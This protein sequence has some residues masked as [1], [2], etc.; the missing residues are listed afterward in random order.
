MMSSACVIALP[1]IMV[2][3]LSSGGC[4][5]FHSRQGAPA[6]FHAW[7]ERIKSEPNPHPALVAPAQTA[8]ET[9]AAGA[10]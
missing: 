6:T 3:P 10:V 8:T 5:N 1:S 7:P 2:G 4:W 9:V